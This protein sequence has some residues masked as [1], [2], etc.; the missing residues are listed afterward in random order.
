[1]I[2]TIFCTC[3]VEVHNIFPSDYGDLASSVCCERV[4]IH[5][6]YVIFV[7]V[8]YLIFVHVKYLYVIFVHVKYLYVI[9]VHV[10]YLC[11]YMYVY[12]VYVYSRQ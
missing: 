1:M 8:K 10:K 3:C 9:F 4:R 5:D 11:I 12:N 2:I 7:H 6:L